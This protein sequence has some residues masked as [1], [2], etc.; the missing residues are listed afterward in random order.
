MGDPGFEPGTSSLSESPR[1]GHKQGGTPHGSWGFAPSEGLR[2]A[3]Q[4]AADWGRYRAIVAAL[5]LRRGG[6]QRASAGDWIESIPLRRRGR[7]RWSRGRTARRLKRFLVTQE[8]THLSLEPCQYLVAHRDLDWTTIYLPWPPPT[9]VACKFRLSNPQLVKLF[10]LK[11][12][13]KIGRPRGRS[14]F[15]KMTASSHP[16]RMG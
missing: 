10:A 3:A 8:P 7:R 4:I 9:Q 1:Y 15:I 5:P 6:G 11:H 13:P 2:P 16:F 12:D 14:R